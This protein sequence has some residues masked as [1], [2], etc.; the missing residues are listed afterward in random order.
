MELIDLIRILRKHL[1]LL[2]VTPVILAGLVIF[3]TRSP[4]YRYESTTTLYTGIASGSSV[5]MDKSF[6]YFASNIAFDNLIS[7]IK[8]RETQQEVAIRLLTQHLML[9]RSDPRFISNSSFEKLREL[10]PEYVRRVVV[11]SAPLPR[12]EPSAM[13]GYRDTLDLNSQSDSSDTFSFASLDESNAATK[14]LLPANI[15]PHLFEQN[16]EKLTKLYNSSDT[17]SVYRLLNFVDPHYSIEAISNINVQRITSSDLIQLKYESD[18]PGICQQTLLLFTEVCVKNYKKFKENRSDAVVKYFEFQ[19]GK[20]VNK[21]KKG[22]DQL[23]EFN[24]DNNII[25]YYEQSKA[26]AGVKEELDVDYNNMNIKLAG[27]YAAIKRLEEKLENQ[28]LV[29]LK[30]SKIV[31]LRNQLNE[32]DFKIVS[33]ETMGNVDSLSTQKLADLKVRYER[34]KDELKQAVGELHSYNNS[35]NGVPVSTILTDWINNVIEAEN[36]KAGMSVLKERIAEFQKQ[37]AIFAPAGANLKKI[38]REISVSEQEYLEILHGLNLAKLKLQDNEL[39]SNIKTVDQPYYPLTPIPT[40]RK[41]MILAAAM[42]GFMIVLTTILALE[43]FD[44]T[45]K[46]PVKAASILKLPFLSIFPK[47]L[48]KT[49]NL[50][51]NYVTNRMLEMAVQQIMLHLENLP[52]GQKTKTL[53]F[54]STLNDEGKSV[55]AGN[56]AQKLKNQGEKVLYLDFSR[57]SLKKAETSQM[58]YD[59]EQNTDVSSSNVK[60][61]PERLSV[62]NWLLGYPDDRINHDSPFLKRP[63]HYLSKDECYSYQIDEKFYAAKSYEDIIRGSYLEQIKK[64]D[65]VLI[66]LP[67]ILY[68]PFPVGLFSKADLSALVCRSNRAWSVADQGVL[69]VVLQVAKPKTFFVLNG[70]ELPVIESILGDLPKRRSKIRRMIKQFFRFQ[71]FSRNA[72]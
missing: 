19:L 35:S 71:F 32:L 72:F 10:T 68:Y 66:V 62:L 42:L 48:L 43:F 53:L 9:T 49:G 59:M 50:N 29:E 39:S 61:D 31:E 26:V 36:V 3:L 6:N 1:V 5:E 56:L 44:N 41:I 15:D 38:E 57:E 28:H 7:I 16:V 24:K 4:S 13:A 21:L 47:I 2:A 22:E 40:K 27:H 12:K 63:E 33:L 51:F 55:V 64:P 23:L 20:A 30:S 45:L 65:F 37:Y 46:N 17:N 25:N 58:G 14:S 60:K 18:D 34:L 52:S 11:K 54:F 70:V 8:S 69:D 67:A